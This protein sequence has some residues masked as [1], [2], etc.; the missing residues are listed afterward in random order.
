MMHG[1]EDL[2]G[3]GMFLIQPLVDEAEWVKGSAG[4]G[5]YVRWVIKLAKESHHELS[6]GI[7]LIYQAW[8]T[9]TAPPTDNHNSRKRRLRCP[10]M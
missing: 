7:M 3:M 8:G 10:N 6:V 2:R 1:D 5:S 4:K 9:S